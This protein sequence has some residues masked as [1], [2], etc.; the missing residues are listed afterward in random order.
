MENADKK[1]AE[2]N[3]IIGRNISRRRE[4]LGLSQAQLA[5][6]TGL[7]I[8]SISQ[9]E[10][11]HSQARR[12][13]LDAIA[14]ALGCSRADLYTSAESAAAAQKDIDERK[15]DAKAMREKIAGQRVDDE[16]A[17][18]LD[19]IEGGLNELRSS[20]SLSHDESEILALFRRAADLDLG[21]DV[22][23][24]VRA[25]IAVGDKGKARPRRKSGN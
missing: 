18:R 1:I 17:K 25:M 20:G 16:L 5:K 13:N 24:Q 22:L 15:L 23:R 3:K 2:A 7:T 12:S 6:S 9:I 14:N 11:G 8:K 19:A 4:D 10:N 21:L